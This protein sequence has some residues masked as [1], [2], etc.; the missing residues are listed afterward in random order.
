[1]TNI[2]PENNLIFAAAPNGAYK[3]KADHPKIPLRD[4]ELV[5]FGVNAQK[6]G[7]N[8]LHLHIRD[9]QNNH[10]LDANHYLDLLTTISQKLLEPMALQATSEAA[11][12]FGVEAQIAMIETVKPEFV[13]IAIREIARAGEERLRTFFAGLKHDR[14]NPQ[15]II[16]NSTDAEMYLD[17]LTNGSLVG[18]KFPLLYV[19]GRNSVDQKNC[20]KGLQ[21]V[22]GLTQEKAKSWMVCG[23]EHL[24]NLV[25]EYALAHGGHIRIGFENNLYQ[26]NGRQA[27]DNEARI[28]EI[29]KLIQ[30][31]GREIASH[32][33]AKNLLT[34]DWE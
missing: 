33:V 24:E 23:F 8:M 12:M 26:S 10:S 11:N 19:V 17:Y 16:Y 4:E 14:V 21:E 3:T 6:L 7:V 29:A 27:A 34:P 9:N 28:E 2:L 25:C 15:L 18:Q 31:Q 1:M 5:A 20:L 22:R 13:S 30:A 32:E